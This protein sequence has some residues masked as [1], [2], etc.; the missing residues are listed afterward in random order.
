MKW[1][2]KIWNTSQIVIL[3]NCFIFIPKKHFMLFI[4]FVGPDIKQA[5]RASLSLFQDFD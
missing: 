1:G 4:L 5:Q 2:Q 3:E